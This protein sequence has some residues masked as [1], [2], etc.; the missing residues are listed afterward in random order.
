MTRPGRDW[1]PGI[2]L[3]P[4]P[5]AGPVTI[6]TQALVHLSAPFITLSARGAC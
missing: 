5:E 6:I 4:D 1:N 2:M 3:T